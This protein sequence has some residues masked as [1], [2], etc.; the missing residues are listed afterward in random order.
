M[1]NLTSASSRRTFMQTVIAGAGAMAAGALPLQSLAQTFGAPQGMATPDLSARVVRP[2]LF[3]AALAALARHGD[4]IAYHDRIA[5]ADFAAPSATPRL[6]LVD[7]ASRETTTVL[8]AH[9]R[10]SD[11]EHTGWLQHFSNDPG[12]Y[13]S[14]DGAFLAAD[15]YVGKHGQSQRLIG[16]DPTNDNALDRAIVIHSAWYA[17]PQVAA[18]HGQLGR[19]EGCF[20]VSESD[21]DRVFALLGPGRMLFAAKA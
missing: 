3:R 9:G 19:S 5:I 8:V 4:R 15:Y 20:A 18:S 16:L 17:D 1:R 2:V 13:A 21:L 12:S 14:C 11:P 7:L 6:H 10:G